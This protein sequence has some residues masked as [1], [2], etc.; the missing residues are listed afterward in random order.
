[1]SEVP[2]TEITPYFAS[3]AVYKDGKL[4][5]EATRERFQLKL[6]SFHVRTQISQEDISQAVHRVFDKMGK[7][8]SSMAVI[9]ANATSLLNPTD[10]IEI[11]V[12]L[13][14]RVKEFIE[15]RTFTDNDARNGKPFY[16]RKRLGVVRVND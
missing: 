2:F 11:M 14:K 13:S 3:I 4:D 10:S 12:E 15:A 9:V 1:M 8:P 7:E 5:L 6:S 16:S